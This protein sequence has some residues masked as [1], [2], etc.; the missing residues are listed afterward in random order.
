MLKQVFWAILRVLVF[1]CMWGIV[2]A[3]M[4]SIYAKER[5]QR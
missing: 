4:A 3:Y 5:R 1:C 2:T